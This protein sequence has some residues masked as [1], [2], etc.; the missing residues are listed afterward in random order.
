M[1]EQTPLLGGEIDS[2]TRNNIDKLSSMLSAVRFRNLTTGYH[3]LSYRRLSLK[4]STGRS[5]IYGIVRPG[6]TCGIELGAIWRLGST[7][8]NFECCE[9]S[10]RA[11][12]ADQVS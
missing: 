12:L 4:T 5:S 9:L 11:T 1:R 7:V 6:P 10:R 2:T 8:V 3:C